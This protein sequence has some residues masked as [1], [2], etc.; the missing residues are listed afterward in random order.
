[1]QLSGTVDLMLSRMP[2]LPHNAAE[3]ELAFPSKA[4][5]GPGVPQDGMGTLPSIVPGLVGLPLWESR[6]SSYPFGMGSPLGTSKGI[7]Q[8]GTGIAVG[9][10]PAGAWEVQQ[11]HGSLAQ[12]HCEQSCTPQVAS[13]GDSQV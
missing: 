11:E 7:L 4:G 1:M 2:Q 9:S 5:L 6:S 3:R 12:S 8:L 10:A 13:T